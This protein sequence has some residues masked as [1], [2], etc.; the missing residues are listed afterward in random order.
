MLNF[1]EIFWTAW[2]EGRPAHEIRLKKQKS[3]W[4]GKR[5]LW[6]LDHCSKH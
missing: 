4:S 1:T 6:K 5:E 2:R 3:Q